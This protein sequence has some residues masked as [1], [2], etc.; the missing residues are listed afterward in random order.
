MHDKEILIRFPDTSAAKSNDFAEALRQDL[1]DAVPGLTVERHRED[2][3]TLDFGA[4]L[5]LVLGAPATL[6]LARAIR[7]WAC[8]TNAARIEFA[9]KDGSFSVKNVDSRDVASIVKAL[10]DISK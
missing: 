10:T 4:T 6:I 9:T 5:I 2:P 1:L 3:T 8:R 7:K